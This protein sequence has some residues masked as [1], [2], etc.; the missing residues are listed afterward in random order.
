MTTKK[1]LNFIKAIPDGFMTHARREL[2]GANFMSANFDTLYAT[3]GAQPVF[4]GSGILMIRFWD[5]ATTASKAIRMDFSK[6]L[7]APGATDEWFDISIVG[8]EPKPSN[9]AITIQPSAPG[10]LQL[11]AFRL[12]SRLAS[13][14]LT[15]RDDFLS[16]K[17]LLGEQLQNPE[18]QSL[19][20]VH[21]FVNWMVLSFKGGQNMIVERDDQLG[22]FNIFINDQ[23]QFLRIKEEMEHPDWG[24]IEMAEVL[25]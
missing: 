8:Q 6:P 13:E 1:Q 11:R 17:H 20:V 14:L 16:Y 24:K 4:Q 23:D 19:Q 3:V 15:D 18:I 9:V 2:A 12:Y 10:D 25:I 21:H 7:F 5:P 22:V